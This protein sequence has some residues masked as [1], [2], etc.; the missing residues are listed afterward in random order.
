MSLLLQRQQSNGRR[1]I[2]GNYYT[3]T[4][5]ILTAKDAWATNQPFDSNHSTPTQLNEANKYNKSRILFRETVWSRQ[6]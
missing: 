1:Q 3:T 2:F 4:M 5:A 6:N